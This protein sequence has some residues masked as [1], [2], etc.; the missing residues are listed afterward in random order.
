M[1]IL[2]TINRTNNKKVN[3]LSEVNLLH[4]ILSTYKR[5]K[6]I[7]IHY[8]TILHGCMSTHKGRAKFKSSRIL[9][10]S[11]CSS[12]IMIRKLITKINPKRDNLMQWHKK[13]GNITTNINVEI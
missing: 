13:A 7:S 8:S 11:G 4:D 6:N 1:K 2:N 5:T 9:F 12:K 3:N 10:N